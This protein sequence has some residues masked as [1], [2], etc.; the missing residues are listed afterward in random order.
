MTKHLLTLADI[1][2]ATLR[3]L[4]DAAHEC[5]RLRGKPGAPKPL[6]ER[7]VAMIFTKSS[8]RTRVSFEVGIFELG[9][10]CLFLEPS[11]IQVG[12]G[13]SMADTAKVLSRYVHGVVIRCHAHEDLEVFA[14]HSSIPVINALTDRYHP[15]QVLA[16][17][18]TIEEQHG[19]LQGIKFAY[20]GDGASNMARSLAIGGKLAGMEVVIAAP[21]GYQLEPSLLDGLEG[22]GS[23]TLTSDPEDAADGADIIYTDV[24]VSMGFEAEAEDRLTALRPYQV[25]DALLARAASHVKV[26]H[27]LPA[28]RGKEITSSVLDGPAAIVWDEAENRVHAQKAVLTWLIGQR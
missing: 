27:C 26:M 3:K 1:D 17:L 11:V 24:W 13:E 25:N 12:R 14:Q 16:D 15:C 2:A 20:F 22:D 28:Y 18:Q 21:D 19:R 5:K 10:N 23:V 8:T 6:A 7:S 4:L 9:G